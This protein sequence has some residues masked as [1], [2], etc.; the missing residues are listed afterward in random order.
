MK[1][2]KM[3]L[4]K[5]FIAKELHEFDLDIP[6][7]IIERQGLA[8]KFFQNK[9]LQFAFLPSDGRIAGAI[10]GLRG[11]GRQGYESHRG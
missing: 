6:L 4:V 1:K 3:F 8:R 10:V 9:D 5:F 7:Q 11:C 2:R